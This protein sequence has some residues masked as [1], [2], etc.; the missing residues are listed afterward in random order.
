[1][2]SRSLAQSAI[3]TVKTETRTYQAAGQPSKRAPVIQEDINEFRQAAGGFSTEDIVKAGL[4]KFRLGFM[5]SENVTGKNTTS[6]PLPSNVTNA[7]TLSTSTKENVIRNQQIS[8]AKTVMGKIGENTNISA[9]CFFFTNCSYTCKT[10]CDGDGHPQKKSFSTNPNMR[11]TDYNCT[12]VATINGTA[13]WKEAGGV[14]KKFFDSSR[15]NEIV[16]TCAFYETHWYECYGVADCSKGDQG[17][18][19]CAGSAPWR[20]FYDASPLGGS[21]WTGNVTQE[22]MN[23]GGSFPGQKGPADT[24]VL[25]TCN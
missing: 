8:P 2:L 12:D 21:G 6:T 11:Y 3:L 9:H 10:N 4:K 7:E 23:G 1:M 17:I 15:K 13:Q 20:G 5:R 19:S 24:D 14:V 22:A 18:L 25:R 16:A